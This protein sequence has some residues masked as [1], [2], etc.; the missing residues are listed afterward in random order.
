MNEY[1]CLC[2]KLVPYVA[3]YYRLDSSLNEFIDRSYCCQLCFIKLAHSFGALPVF[4]EKGNVARWGRDLCLWNFDSAWYADQRV[5]EEKK[6]EKEDRFSLKAKLLGHKDW[7]TAYRNACV[8][9]DPDFR[10]YSTYLGIKHRVEE[11]Y[12]LVL[13][14]HYWKEKEIFSIYEPEQI[15]NSEL[16][17][18]PYDH[19]H[20]SQ[21]IS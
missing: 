21:P 13:W 7:P 9:D 17:N 10:D 16:K 6:Q 18:V 12:D 19:G 4:D 15:R 2:K 1:C 5:A 3:L 8:K 11:A 20:K 14:D